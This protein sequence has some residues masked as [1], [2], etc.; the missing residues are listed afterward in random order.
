MPFSTINNISIS[1]ERSSFTLIFLKAAYN[2]NPELE[3]SFSGSCSYVLRHILIK[4]SNT[5]TNNNV[6][7]WTYK[8]WYSP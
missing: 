6:S 5:L 8:S 3:I 2:T 7:L 1:V 4:F